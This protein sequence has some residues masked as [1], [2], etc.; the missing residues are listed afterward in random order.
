MDMILER[1]ENGSDD[2]A[3]PIPDEMMHE[4]K[5]FDGMK[6]ALHVEMARL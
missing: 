2:L 3:M 5:L 6:A 4:L 1:W